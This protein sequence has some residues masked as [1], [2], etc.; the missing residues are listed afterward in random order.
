MLGTAAEAAAGQQLER[1]VAF[2]FTGA[3]LLAEATA[4]GVICFAAGP[5]R[6]RFG[7][8]PESFIGQR[9][10]ALIAPPDQATFSVTLGMAA[11]HGR[12]A[13]VVLHLNDAACTP[14]AVAAMQVPGPN[15]RLCL[16]FGPVP[17]AV[18]PPPA[19]EPASLGGAGSF[20]REAEAWLR[21]SASGSLGLVDVPGW[22]AAREAMSKPEFEGLRARIGAALA[23]LRPGTL[24]GELAEGRFGVLSAGPLDGTALA[25]EVTAL[26]RD[27]PARTAGDADGLEIALDGHGLT[28]F[29]AVRAARFALG[30]F[31]MSGTK[32][33][34]AEG[35]GQG[36]AGVIAQAQ[37][38]A[39]G[40]RTAIRERQF[41]LGFQPVVGLGDRAV[42]HHEAL[43]RPG[44]GGAAPA[45]TPQEFVTF[46]EA[47]GL[48][49]ELD[50]AVLERSIAEL[51]R[52]RGASV[53]VNVSGQSMQS[54][55]FRRRMLQAI[56]AG[57]RLRGA[58]G[59]PRL[60]VELTETAE[61]EDVAGAAATI[62][63]LRAAGV[64]VCIDDF[65]AGNAAFRY[66]RD[67][68]VDFV[69]IDGSY[70]QGAVHNAQERNF[71]TA[72]VNLARSVGA[73]VVAEMIETEAQAT[74]MA[75]LQV[76][77]GQGW[78]FGRPGKLVAAA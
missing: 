9:A 43:L 17:A 28:P 34:L 1:W 4:E 65:G 41:R 56:A 35:A 30:R 51:G 70:V 60:I 10:T 69:K 36:L 23:A 32:A 18:P 53:A 61:I 72:M 40:L 46:A 48:S 5:F 12:T 3:D 20:G 62:G 26:L 21:G 45:H 71:V 22:N 33:V 27:T 47:V 63:E 2:A 67:F 54:P 73:Q 58:G 52:I 37:A 31:A 8:D 13:P 66:L 14:C 19:S 74:L 77:F 78:L 38:Q 24:A 57:P 59:R 75:T 7:A 39:G 49:E 25:G 11:L 42:H 64:P 68:A 50:F 16:T 15:K 29:Q 44:A 76:E 6:L 55:G